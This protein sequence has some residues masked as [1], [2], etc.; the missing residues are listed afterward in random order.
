MF[1][2]DAFRMMIGAAEMRVTMNGLVVD[3]AHL[4]G[5]QVAEV[6]SALKA[7]MVRRAGGSLLHPDSSEHL[8]NASVVGYDAVEASGNANGDLERL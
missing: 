4:P 5:C 3:A 8:G 7:P 2:L 1:G 6:T